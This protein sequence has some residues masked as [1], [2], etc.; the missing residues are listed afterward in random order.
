MSRAD[1]QRK[2]YIEVLKALNETIE[3]A[4]WGDNLFLQAI[5]KKLIELREQFKLEAH[6][7][8]ADLESPHNLSAATILGRIAQRQG[9]QEV[10]IMIYNADGMNISKWEAIVN[11][12]Q[13]HSVNR[14]VYEK[15]EFAKAALRGAPNKQNEAYISLFVAQSDILKSESQMLVDRFGNPLILL[16]DNAVQREHICR[17]VHKSG[18]Y[19]FESPKLVWTDAADFL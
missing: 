1:D 7:T 13:K 5:R 15:E 17:F 14:P 16:K 11:S 10:F 3:Q 4:P 2:N 9:L 19:E 12:I 18:Q 8:D 6:I